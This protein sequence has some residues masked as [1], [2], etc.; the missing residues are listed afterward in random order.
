[1]HLVF[2]DAFQVCKEGLQS[3]RNRIEQST[4]HVMSHMLFS[5]RLD[6]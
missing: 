2:K 5:K 3:D 4:Y 1:M 6:I